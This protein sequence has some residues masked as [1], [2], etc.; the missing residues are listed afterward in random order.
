LLFYLSHLV[1]GYT[2][3]IHSEWTAEDEINFYSLIVY[4]MLR[5]QVFLMNPDLASNGLGLIFYPFVDRSIIGTFFDE[6]V[7]QT[8]YQ[9][10]MYSTYLTE[11]SFEAISELLN[12]V[13]YFE[14]IGMIYELSSDIT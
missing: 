10:P 6:F 9:L 13:R 1:G 2:Q 5:S 3:P 4:P 11:P 7:Q 14:S 12:N 8:N